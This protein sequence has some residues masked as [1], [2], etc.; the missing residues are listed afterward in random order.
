LFSHPKASGLPGEPR[1]NGRLRAVLAPHIDY[2]RGGLAYTYA[3]RSV[4]GMDNLG[5]L[6][7][8]P[9]ASGIPK[10]PSSAG[11]NALSGDEKQ[12][13]RRQRRRHPPGRQE[14]PGADDA[15]EDEQDRGP[16][17]ERADQPFISL[18]G[19]GRNGLAAVAATAGT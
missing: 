3:N 11:N 15:A 4:Q 19:R 12:R 17:A 9:R 8:F 5:D 16:E 6:F 7:E 13:R 1:N 2:H 14:D 10:H 18:N